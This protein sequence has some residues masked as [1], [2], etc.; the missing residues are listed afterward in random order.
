MKYVRD[1]IFGL[2]LVAVCVGIGVALCQEWQVRDARAA[3]SGPQQPT[4]L[5]IVT[6]CIPA[7]A[8]TITALRMPRLAFEVQ[9]VG[10]N[11]IWCNM[12]ATAPTVGTGRRIA[13]GETWTADQYGGPTDAPTS[14]V[15]RMQCIAETA[16]QTGAACTNFTT[17]Y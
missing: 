1:M 11:P 16:A 17:A 4:R 14:T 10:P 15:F 12:G 3:I 9:N 5:V 7:T 6:Q 8:T 2:L 13:S